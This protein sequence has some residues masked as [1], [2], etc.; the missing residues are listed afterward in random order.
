M[1]GIFAY[2]GPRPPQEALIEG[3]KK[4]EYRGYDS[5]GMAFFE[6][7]KIQSIKALGDISRL[8]ERLQKNSANPEINSSEKANLNTFLG[9]GHTR[10]AT[11]GPPTEENAHPSPGRP[12]LCHPQRS[13]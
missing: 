3:L 6:G 9:M 1:C 8:Q 12:C 7:T 2:I 11:H 4:L 13:D 5:S 10:W